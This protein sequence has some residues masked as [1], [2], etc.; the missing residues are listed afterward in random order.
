[1]NRAVNRVIVWINLMT[2]NL[3]GGGGWEDHLGIAYGDK[4]SF[5]IQIG[6]FIVLSRPKM[7]KKRV[8]RHKSRLF[9]IIEIK[10]EKKVKTQM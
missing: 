5:L 9:K 10:S 4:K 2:W 6:Q 7:Q 3:G 1:L 8:K